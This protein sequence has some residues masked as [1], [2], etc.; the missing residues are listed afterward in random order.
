MGR[1]QR[2]MYIRYRISISP[3]I[4]KTGTSKSKRSAVTKNTPGIVTIRRRSRARPIEVCAKDGIQRRYLSLHHLDFC[5]LIV[6]IILLFYSGII[7][8]RRDD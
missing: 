5:I 8:R 6:A 1:G 2:Q 4:T 7:L 3:P